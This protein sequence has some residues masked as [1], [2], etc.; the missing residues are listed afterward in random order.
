MA[1]PI[2]RTCDRVADAGVYCGACAAGIMASALNPHFRGRRK[3]LPPE[4][5]TLPR[6]PGSTVG[7]TSGQQRLFR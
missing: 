7:N 1:N 4:Q 2:C 5:R 6:R 3:K